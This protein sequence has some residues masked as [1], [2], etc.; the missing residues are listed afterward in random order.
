V[1]QATTFTEYVYDI[2]ANWKLTYDNFQEN[3]HLRFIHP[4]TGTPTFGK[5]NPFGYPE[6]FA[7]HG[8]H[9]T[10]AIWSNPAPTIQPFQ[11]A[12]AGKGVAAVM[13]RNLMGAPDSRTY[14]ALYPNFFLF[15]NPIQHFLHT[16]FPISPEK[17]RGVIR[18][19]WVGEPASA[20]EA[21][22][23][24]HFA[25]VARDVHAED[26]AVIEAGQRGLSSGALSHIHFQ[27]QEA[28]CRH[29]MTGVETAV[30]AWQ[31]SQ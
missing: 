16:V 14:F 26:R 8:Q 18:L 1:G 21:F 22:A 10:Q 29:L 7:F 3:Y 15:G 5:E 9:R 19:Y 31:A 6:S 27:E 28:L 17:S 25:A 23:R 24:E 13:R 30:A 20:S 11:M 12:A 2:D 4:K